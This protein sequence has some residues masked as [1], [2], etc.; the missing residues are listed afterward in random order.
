MKFNVKW[1]LLV[2][3]S[4]FCRFWVKK[5]KT[6]HFRPIR[7]PFCKNT[8]YA[9]K[10]TVM[11][12]RDVDY[13]EEVTDDEGDDEEETAKNPES[14][15]N[16]DASENVEFAGDKAS[17]KGQSAK[18]SKPGTPKS[19]DSQLNTEGDEEEAKVVEKVKKF[20]IVTKTKQEEY[21]TTETTVFLSCGF[22]QQIMKLLSLTN[23]RSTNGRIDN[24]VFYL[25]RIQDKGPV[26]QPTDFSESCCILPEFLEFGTLTSNSL[27]MLES[28]LANVYEPLFEKNI[29]EIPL[30]FRDELLAGL[31]RFVTHMKRTITQLE[32]ETRLEVP[33]HLEN[34]TT[35]QQ[36]S[37]IDLEDL[38]SVVASW[39]IQIS[40][41]IEEQVRLKP[42]GNGPLA[43]IEFWCERKAALSALAEQ[44]KLSQVE[45]TLTTLQR[46]QSPTAQNFK[47][48]RDELVKLHIEANENVR[49]LSTLERHF[50]NLTQGAVGFNNVI[51]TIPTMMNSLRMVWIIS[52]HYN[53]DERM[54]PLMER[55]AWALCDRVRRI[56]NIK[57]IYRQTPAQVKEMT[58]EAKNALELWRSSYFE[59]RAQIEA[60][61]RDPRWEFDKKKLFEKTDYIA[62]ICGDL[63]NIA[64]VSFMMNGGRNTILKPCF[65]P[66]CR[67]NS[68]S[69]FKKWSTYF[70]FSFLIL[71]RRQQL[72]TD[73]AKADTLDSFFIALTSHD[74]SVHVFTKLSLSTAVLELDFS[75]S[76]P[77]QLQHTSQTRVIRP[78]NST[79]SVQISGVRVAPVD[80]VVRELLFH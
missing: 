62:K 56:I 21:A 30:A 48:S 55:I 42:A 33:D 63:Y 74:D 45:N 69:L 10:E 65:E 3:S 18:G 70:K 32:N 40:T 41:S 67:P 61:N 77:T 71:F 59:V 75:C 23:S 54:V 24:P 51:D 64:Q 5:I 20:K 60:S 44:L 2:N 4:L 6:G 11:K 16:G 73:L 46:Y 72:T 1:L 79:T 49:F 37:N 39:Q 27:Q 14:G 38:E 12:T 36:I 52:R 26:P 50:K 28:V 76:L 35:G 53:K 22:D 25:S 31:N 66:N 68:L 15:E 78:R 43:E 9:T 19:S 8:L 29:S 80:G 13:E 47:L 7:A 34:Y 57:S 17:E 58:S